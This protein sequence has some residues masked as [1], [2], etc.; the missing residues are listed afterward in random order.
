M[1]D[2]NGDGVLDFEEFYQM[3]RKYDWLFMRMMHK[4]V[5]LVVPPPRRAQRAGIGK[6][7]SLNKLPFSLEISLQINFY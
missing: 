7:D 1:S 3:S 2:K 6:N 5:N 4:Y